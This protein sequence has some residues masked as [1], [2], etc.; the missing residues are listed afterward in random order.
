MLE[1]TVRNANGHLNDRHRD[2]AAKKLGK[3]DRYF[4]SASRLELAHT[5]EKRG[6]KI[7]V[8]VFADGMHLRGEETD[9]HVNAAIDKVADKLETRLRRLKSR[10]IKRHRH[11]GAQLPLGLQESEL[12]TEEEPELDEAVHIAHER[13]YD[14]RPMSLEDA[15]LY[16]EMLDHPFF[17][18]HNVESN[19]VEVLYKRKDGSYALV[20]PQT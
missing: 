13:H 6:H 10:L 11:K 9:E 4:H 1:V 14:M 12:Q 5:E 18:F 8:T 16:L 2:Y 3:L 20:T 19:R 17:V 7:E 15:G